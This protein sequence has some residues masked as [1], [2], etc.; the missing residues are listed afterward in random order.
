LLHILPYSYSHVSGPMS[1]YTSKYDF[2]MIDR[3]GEEPL[4]GACKMY[5]FLSDMRFSQ[6]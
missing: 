1:N 5:T 4:L 6:Q 2:R 3:T